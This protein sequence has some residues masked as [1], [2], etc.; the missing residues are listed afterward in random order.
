MADKKIYSHRE[1]LRLASETPGRMFVRGDAYR[2]RV[3]EKGVV[4]LDVGIG[5]KD[6]AGAFM[7]GYTFTDPEPEDMSPKEPELW[8]QLREEDAKQG[9]RCSDAYYKREAARMRVVARY[10]L[11]R[12]KVEGFWEDCKEWKHATGIR[13]IP[14]GDDG[15]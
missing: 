1:A 4:Q 3:S 13:I 8:E 12:A 6:C 14:G 10:E 11:A 15:K 7:F 5:W 9:Y 2:A